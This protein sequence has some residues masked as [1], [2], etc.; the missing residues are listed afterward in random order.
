MVLVEFLYSFLLAKRLFGWG[1]LGLTFFL[2]PFG[3]G[4]KES[5]FRGAVGSIVINS[6]LLVEINVTVVFQFRPVFYQKK[7][8]R[9]NGSPEQ[10]E[11]GRHI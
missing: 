3:A 6:L 10:E 9:E 4:P 11:K 8:T 7:K 2:E 5:N 1:R